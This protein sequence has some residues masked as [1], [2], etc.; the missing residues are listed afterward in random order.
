MYSGFRIDFEKTNDHMDW[1]FTDFLSDRNGF[2][3]WRKRTK[4]YLSFG[5]FAILVNDRSEGLMKS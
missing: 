4:G 3:V 2:E 5:S 1:N